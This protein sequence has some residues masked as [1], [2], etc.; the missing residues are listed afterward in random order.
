MPTECYVIPPALPNLV[1]YAVR[2]CPLQLSPTAVNADHS[3]QYSCSFSQYPKDTI[4]IVDSTVKT[5]DL[6]GDESTKT[7]DLRLSYPNLNVPDNCLTKASL[8]E[9]CDT[10]ER[11]KSSTAS[12]DQGGSSFAGILS[13][14]RGTS[15][16]VI[17]SPVQTISRTSHRT[18]APK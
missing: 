14:L 8:N 10:K 1:S 7:L 4:Q 17:P 2:G 12:S 11:A 16:N 15:I 9:T 3:K 13:D 6:L 18:P 5:S